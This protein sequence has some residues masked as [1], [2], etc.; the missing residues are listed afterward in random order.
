MPL[1][2]ISSMLVCAYRPAGR[3]EGAPATGGKLLVAGAQLSETAAAGLVGAEE[4][5]GSEEAGPWE[6]QQQCDW[7]LGEDCAGLDWV[8]R[9]CA[10]LESHKIAA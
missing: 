3:G 9:A 1:L 10:S 2:A 8:L 7:S 5:A 6:Y 4:A